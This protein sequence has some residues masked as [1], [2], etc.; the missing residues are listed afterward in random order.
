MRID[1]DI[2]PRPPV[3]AFGDNGNPLGH[4]GNKPDLIGPHVPQPSHA[5]SGTLDLCF[6][7]QAAR[8]AVAFVLGVLK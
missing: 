3:Q 8:H 7:P 1:T 2:I 4:I 6:L 5:R